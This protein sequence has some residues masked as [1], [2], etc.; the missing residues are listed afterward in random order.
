MCST[1]VFYLCL[2]CVLRTNFGTFQ[3]KQKPHKYLLF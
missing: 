1:T 3:Q 2:I